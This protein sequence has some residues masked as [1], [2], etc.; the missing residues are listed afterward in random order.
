MN[1]TSLH[2]N[3]NADGNHE[4]NGTR[5][6]LNESRESV[7]EQSERSGLALQYASLFPRIWRKS[8]TDSNMS[9]HGFRRFKTSHLVNLRFME[10]EI[11]R[12][13]HEIYQA[14]LHLGFQIT[15]RDRLGLGTS[16]LDVEFHKLEESITRPLVL[17]LRTML[18]DYGWST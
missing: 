17:R 5:T 8:T 6:S 11:A 16:K 10:E 12:I 7:S 15:E 4:R 3:L 9:L 18:K 2:D 14:G 13:D 1:A